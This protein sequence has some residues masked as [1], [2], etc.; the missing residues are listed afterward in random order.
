M[1]ACVCDCNMFLGRIAVLARCGLCTA[2]DGIVWSG[3]VTISVPSVCNDRGPCK[4]G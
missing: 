1:N 4:S 2:A 3:L